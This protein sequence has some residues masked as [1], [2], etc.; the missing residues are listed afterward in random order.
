[1]TASTITESFLYL[2]LPKCEVFQNFDSS[3]GLSKDS[4]IKCKDFSVSLIKHHAILNTIYHSTV[5]FLIL[6]GRKGDEY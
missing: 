5:E 1:M 2:S 3:F 4:S 6:I